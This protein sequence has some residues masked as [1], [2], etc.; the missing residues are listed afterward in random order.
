M[1]AVKKPKIA[2]RY[3]ADWSRYRMKPSKK[4]A[5]HAFC[6]VCNVDISIAA[7]GKNDVERHLKSAK[8]VDG[9]SKGKS[10]PTLSTFM[11][12]TSASKT[13]EDQAMAAEIYFAKFVAEHNL[14]FLV[15]D[16]FSRLTKVMFPDSKIA[17]VYSSARTKTSAII[18]H[19]LAPAF[20]EEVVQLCRSAPFT[21]LCDGGND[22]VDRKYFAILV[23]LWDDKVVHC[24]TR[25]L[26]MPVCNIATAEKL[27]DAI[28][29]VMEENAIPWKNVVGYASDTA[30][31]MV[32]EHNSVLSRVREKQ[33]KV[34]SLGCLCHLANLCSAAA[35]KTLPISVDNLLI[36]IF[37]HFKYS[38]KRWEEF[39]EI[40]SEF[41]D[42]KPLRALKH[43]TTR[44]LSLLRCLKRLLHQWPALHSYFDRLAE[45]ERSND[46]VQRVAK[47][48]KSLEVKLICRFVQFALQPL[49]K[50]TTVFQTNAS[51]IGSIH[52]DT[53]SLLRSYLANFIK[54]EVITGAE[55]IKSIDY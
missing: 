52:D 25:F 45:V 22:Q 42:I 23:R 7:G 34:F 31:V 18:T 48:L 32:G 47:S 27:F 24:V 46:R 37:Y 19:A 4:S 15:A 20:R 54:P 29:T 11:A 8:H 12:Q 26:A 5:S 13:V 1:Y 41:E 17:D 2:C 16:H 10:Q 35:L 14:P 44:W 21:I 30:N 3:K 28:N 43:S 49:N 53:L 50:F 9:L 39:S 55:D 51:R 6:T 33:P 38:A 36:D 40:Q